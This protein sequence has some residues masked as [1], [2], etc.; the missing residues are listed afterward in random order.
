MAVKVPIHPFVLGEAHTS[1]GGYCMPEALPIFGSQKRK[2]SK[3]IQI[4]QEGL[5]NGALDWRFPFQW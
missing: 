3:I 4:L 1:V 2:H 5:R